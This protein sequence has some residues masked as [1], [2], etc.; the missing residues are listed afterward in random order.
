METAKPSSETHKVTLARIPRVFQGARPQPAGS[1]AGA[2]RPRSLQPQVGALGYCVRFAFLSSLRVN[3]AD[4]Q[5]PR[6]A[7]AQR[8]SAAAEL[9][10]GR[11][12]SWPSWAALACRCA[13]AVLECR[14]LGEPHRQLNS[15]PLM[16]QKR[17][18]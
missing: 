9:V 12:C 11:R 18:P 1:H 6:P 16:S 8:G 17:S 7:A 15:L 2:S 13:A 4:A 5:R 3:G 14:H 10:S